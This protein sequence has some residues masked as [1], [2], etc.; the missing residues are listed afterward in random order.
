MCR[1]D[2]IFESI[3]WHHKLVIRKYF[4]F[5]IFLCC[6]GCECSQSRFFSFHNHKKVTFSSD[7]H[8]RTFF[9]RIFLGQ[10]DQHRMKSSSAQPFVFGLS[11]KI[12]REKERNRNR[13]QSNE[14]WGPCARRFDIF[15]ILFLIFYAVE[16]AKNTTV[17]PTRVHF[18]CSARLIN[19][20][21]FFFFSSY[22]NVF[23]SAGGVRMLAR[24]YACQYATCRWIYVGII[25]LKTKK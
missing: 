9:S 12:L 3:V 25:E 11:K 6:F 20:I 23:E 7:S 22:F 18:P 14:R 15:F 1:D 2:H 24:V 21:F 19:I 8:R 13:L 17:N 4:L 5:S 10:S 16:R